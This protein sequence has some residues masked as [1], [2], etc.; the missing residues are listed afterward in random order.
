MTHPDVRPRARRRARADR[1]HARAR[2]QR[3]RAARRLRRVRRRRAARRPRPRRRRQVQARLRRGARGRD[4]RAVAR[5]D[6]A[7]WP[8]TPARPGRCSP[9]SASSRSRPSRSATRCA[10]SGRLEGFEQDPIVP[11]VEQWRYRNK[12]EYSFGTGAGRDAR[13]RLPRARP[14]RRDPPARRLPARLRARQRVR[15]SRCSAGAASRASRRWDRRDQRGLLRN[16]VVREG[17]RTGELQVRLVTSPG[18]IDTD[19]LAAAVDCEGLFW[20]QADRPRREHPGRRDEAAQRLQAP[21]RAARRPGVPD[22][23]GGVLPDQHRDGRGALRRRRRVR[24]AARARARLRPLLRHRHDRPLARQPRARGGRRGDRRAGRRRRDR[25]RAPQR[26][27]QRVASSPA[28]S[29]WRCASW[30]SRR[31]SPTSA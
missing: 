16:L 15:A 25:Q 12:L 31:A 30:S 1:R 22:L 9:T 29:G 13:V 2:R 7:A 6:R 19:S 26:D 17:R 21:A 28:T 8:T 4:P 11:A 18:A 14:L 23:A 5:P 20:T 3:R 24:R 27:H 10:A